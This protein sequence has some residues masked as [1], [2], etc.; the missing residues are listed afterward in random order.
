MAGCGFLHGRGLLAANG[1]CIGAAATEPAAGFR[2]DRAGQ[3]ALHTGAR[4]GAGQLG[5]RDGNA[6]QQALGV[7]VQRVFV[8]LFGIAAFHQ[9]AQVHHADIIRN[10]THHR[11]VVGDKQVRGTFGLLIVT[12]Q[13]DDLRLNGNVQC[14]DGLIT[15]DQRGVQ[16]QGAG[17]ADALAL[18][19]GKLVGIPS[20]VFCRQANAVQHG[21]DFFVNFLLAFANMVG[22]QRLGNDIAHRHAGVQRSIRILEDHLHV[23]AHRLHLAGLEVGDILPVEDDLALRRLINADDGACAA[24]FAA[25]RLANQAKGAAAAQRK[26]DVIYCMNFRVRADR[27][28][29]CQV[30]YLKN[31]LFH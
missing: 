26:V 19:A 24:A 28:E 4:M 11:K 13:V 10:V 9:L 25:A 14:G 6:A 31:G 23:A 16:H 7:G 18:A 15:D 1:L 22:F 8:D 20:G 12:Q 2:V 3:I 29:F 5:V 30:L 21:K 17:N 27:K